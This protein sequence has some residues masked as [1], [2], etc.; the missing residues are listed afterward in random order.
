MSEKNRHLTACRTYSRTLL[1]RHFP[2]NTNVPKRNN[3]R[4]E[5]PRSLCPRKFGPVREKSVVRIEMMAVHT[6]ELTGQIRNWALLWAKSENPSEKWLLKVNCCRQMKWRNVL[7][8]TKCWMWINLIV[9][10]LHCDQSA[11]SLHQFWISGGSEFGSRT[12]ID[13]D[14]WFHKN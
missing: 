2:K 14:W 8:N 3:G 7:E 4:I 12:S 5:A 1:F 6:G 13:T 10:Q 11:L 9:I